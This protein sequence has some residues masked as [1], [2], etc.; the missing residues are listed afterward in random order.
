MASEPT[1]LELDSIVKQYDSTSTTDTLA[2]LNRV[3]L[4]VDRG[5]S[6]AIVGPSGSGKSTC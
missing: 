5:D 4:R 6:V 3:K 2:I 1:L